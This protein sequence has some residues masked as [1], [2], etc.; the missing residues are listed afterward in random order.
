MS[1]IITCS[2]GTGST[3]TTTC[4]TSEQL[5]T[6]RRTD[7]TRSPVGTPMERIQFRKY[8]RTYA[9]TCSI[10]I[11]LEF[12]HGN[13]F[14]LRLCICPLQIVKARRTFVFTWDGNI[15][16]V[17]RGKVSNAVILFPK[18]FEWKWSV[19][20]SSLDRILKR[21]P[22][23]KIILNTSIT[24]PF[25]LI[26]IP[27]C[28]I[29]IHCRKRLRQ[30]S[31]FR[32]QHRYGIIV[33]C[34]AL[35]KRLESKCFFQCGCCAIAVDVGVDPIPLRI[36]I[37]IILFIIVFILTVVIQRILLPIRISHNQS[38]RYIPNMTTFTRVHPHIFH[39]LFQ[40]RSVP[41]RTFTK[42][43]KVIHF[44]TSTKR[45]CIIIFR[46]FGND[47]LATKFEFCRV[48]LRCCIFRNGTFWTR[49]RG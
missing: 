21:Q 41:L 4:R 20:I 24:K 17:G 46:K 36:I 22:T 43:H 48:T 2:T 7:Q 34:K 44:I 38:N 39:K 18:F 26:K 12:V 33:R 10:Y 42:R 32:Q 19:C 29:P 6:K 15:V 30:T 3:T 14:R 25:G 37:P 47:P 1:S 49:S 5:M 16:A 23:R 13:I 28:L 35:F 11:R 27:L 40:T 31:V 9:P 45:Q 8:I